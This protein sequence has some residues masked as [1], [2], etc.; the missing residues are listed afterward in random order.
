MILGVARRRRLQ[1]AP[2]QGRGRKGANGSGGG[3][4]RKKLLNDQAKAKNKGRAGP[5]QPVATSST[6]RTG[7]EYRTRD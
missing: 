1:T 7:T 6:E 3:D 2:N 5:G 4:L